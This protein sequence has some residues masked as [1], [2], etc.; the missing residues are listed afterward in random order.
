MII[1][2][3]TRNLYSVET[4]FCRTD[5]FKYSFFPYS[6]SEWNKLGPDLRN[7]KSYSR[8]SK[9]HLRI[10]R[11]SPNNISKIHDSLGLKLLTRL[12]IGLSHLN[13]HRFN[14][15]VDSC[16]N[17]LYSCSLEMESTKHFFLHCHHYTSTGKTFL[18]TVEMSMMMI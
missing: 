14:H 10:G 9:S 4:Y 11:P 12:R 3:N 18:N 6:I 8:F 13:E 2:L 7:G 1:E 15:N 5:A 17:P 16:I